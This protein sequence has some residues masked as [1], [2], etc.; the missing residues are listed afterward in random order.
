MI[1]VITANVRNAVVMGKQAS[2][3]LRSA[4]FAMEAGNATGVPGWV[5]S[6]ALAVTGVRLRINVLNAREGG[7][8]ITGRSCG[9][10]EIQCP[11][12][13]GKG[14]SSIIDN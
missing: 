5:A 4:W 9:K 8:F 11:E 14:Y 12:C 2:G 7:G 3:T 6:D 10:V 1:P 13:K